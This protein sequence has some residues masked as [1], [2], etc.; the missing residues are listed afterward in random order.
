MKLIFKYYSPNTK[1]NNQTFYPQMHK[2]ASKY[3][4]FQILGLI[5]FYFMNAKK[6]F[7]DLDSSLKKIFVPSLAWS[8][9]WWW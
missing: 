2:Y 8:P 7:S 9:D 1:K 3:S 6:E 4:K 5:F